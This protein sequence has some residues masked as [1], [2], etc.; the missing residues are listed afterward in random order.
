MSQNNYKTY[1]ELNARLN[2]IADTVSNENI[3]LDDALTLYEEA[4]GLGL[5]GCEMLEVGISENEAESGENPEQ[6][7]E[8][9]QASE[10]HKHSKLEQ[11]QNSSQQEGSTQA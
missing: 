1:D 5:R 11:S 10:M 7:R 4:V 3:P 8:N 2:E 9:I 6:A